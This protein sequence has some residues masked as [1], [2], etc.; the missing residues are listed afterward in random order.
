MRH[1]HARRDAGEIRAG[2][3]FCRMI[4]ENSFPASGYTRNGRF[5]S[6]LSERCKIAIF[7]KLQKECMVFI[8]GQIIFRDIIASGK[9]DSAIL[10]GICRVFGASLL[11]FS[12]AMEI[13]PLSAL[14]CSDESFRY[15]AIC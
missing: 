15:S 3:M 6:L 1:I 10:Y 2:D 9:K 14:L 5:A 11:L 12:A 8:I 7:T 13:D 4:E